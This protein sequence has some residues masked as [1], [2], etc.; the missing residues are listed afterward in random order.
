MEEQHMDLFETADIVIY[1]KGKGVVVKEKSLLAYDMIS[2]KVVAVGNDAEDMIKNPQENIKVISPLR[3]GMIADYVAAVE[4]LRFLFIKAWGKK[5]L[6]K[7]PVSLCV[8][9]E[10]TDVEKKAFLDA[11]Y[12]SGAKE[13][14]ITDIPMEQLLRELPN[15]PKNWQNVKTFISIT[16]EKPECYIAEQIEE[17]LRYAGQEGIARERVKEIFFEKVEAK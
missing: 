2:K 13:L 12:Q 15:L 4:L 7:Q 10:I 6:I 8:P 3:R 17:M 1:I 16:K 14:F 9:K 11:L 5:P